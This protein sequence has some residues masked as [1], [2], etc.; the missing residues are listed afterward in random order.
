MN[1][2]N[3]PLSAPID[4]LWIDPEVTD[5]PLTE[6][7]RKRFPPGKIQVGIP[8]LPKRLSPSGAPRILKRRLFITKYRGRLVK[9]CPGSQGRICCGYQ[10]INA[11][12]HCPM[13][14]HYC[15]L[16][17][18]LSAPALT[19]YVNE[20]QIRNEIT[21]RLTTDPDHIYRF[22]TGELG[23][24]LVH[25]TLTGFSS[26]MVPFFAG[27]KNGI[28]EL[29]TKTAA[30]DTLR[31]LEPRGHTVIS[32]SINPPT[33]IRTVEPLTAT[34][35]QR[36]R[37]ARECQ[38]MGYW[39]GLH[40]DPI[41]WF[42]GWEREYMKVIE[43][44]S[45]TLDPSRILWISMAGLRYTRAQKD[46]IRT[47]FPNTPLF[48]GEFFRDEDGKFRY[49][50]PLRVAIYRTLLLWLRDWSPDLFIYYCM[51]NQHVW[52]ATFP[53]PPRNTRELDERFNKHIWERLKHGN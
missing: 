46:L 3:F 53:D 24:S 17:T 10:V 44:L 7:V 36:L 1:T 28:L 12:I 34:L 35:N 13:D 20:D 51:E 50:Q 25:D 39:I 26:R 15:I 45:H 52:E 8:S 5:H 23:D 11:M 37:A 40:F 4:T 38:E 14:C 21:E 29:K 22:G 47:R 42:D 9:P 19:L 48:T 33:L 32:W 43:R 16:Q 49:L 2:P 30:I 41:I 27:T 31:G 18:Y 6:V